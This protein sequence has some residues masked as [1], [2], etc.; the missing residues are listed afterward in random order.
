MRGGVATRALFA[1]AALVV[2]PAAPAGA[3][4]LP[5]GRPVAPAG[6][7]TALQAFPTGVAAAPDGKTVLAIGGPVIQGGAPAGPSGGVGLMVVDA[8]TG[9]VRQTLN[10]DDAF[11]GVVY[12]PSGTHAYVAGG[13]GATIHTFS[14]ASDG[15]LSQGSDLSAT[16]F[17]SGLAISKDGRT[18]WAAE[19]TANAVEQMDLT[20]RADR[21]RI[22]VPSP[23][24]LALSA[25]GKTLYASD[26]RG[27]CLSA[28][29]L[30]TNRTRCIH[31]GAHPTGVATSK[32][33]ILAA[34]SNDATLA[35]A[36]PGKTSA[37]LMSLA[38]VGRRSD[39][40]NDVVLA[41]D[42]QTAYVSLGADDAVAV[43]KRTRTTSTTAGRPGTRGRA[44]S[45]RSPRHERSH[46]HLRRAAARNCRQAPR[47]RP[48][49]KPTWKL[50][51]LI[52]TG[53][54][55]TALAL[56]PNGRTLH[57]ISARGLGHSAAATQPYSEPDPA[58]T[59]PDGAYGTVGTLETIALPD[60]RGLARDTAVVRAYLQRRT[61]SGD[62]GNPIV[63]GRAGPIKHVIYITRENKT[64]DA[65]LG[66]LHPGP[67]TSLA[68]FG[69]PITPNL[70]ALERTFV[71]AQSFYYQGF[72]STVGHM[73]EDA[74]AVSDLY[75]HTQAA[76]TGAHTSHVS[77]S[78]SDPENYP[79]TG[80]LAEQVWHA[81]MTV[82]TYNEETVQQAHLLPDA[83]QAPTS[84]FPNYNLHISDTSREAGWETEFN[85]F[86]S[87]HCT[88][89]VAATYGTA[90]SLPDFEYVYFGEDHTTIVDEPGYPTIQAQVADNDYATGKLIDAV[91][92]SPD[93]S[94][95]LVIVLDDDPQGTGDHVSEYRGFVAVASPWVKRGL[96][97]TT[98]YDLTSA[99]AAID[100]IL[101][102]PPLTDYA[103]TTRPLD[104]FFTS[105]P[106]ARPFNVDGSGVAANPFVALPGARPAAD[107]RH[108]IYSFTKPDATDPRITGAATWRQV[109]GSAP[110]RVSVP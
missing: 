91:S 68:V 30:K 57:V 2:F 15:T 10:V 72:A 37:K 64:Y 12:D 96:I 89:A 28:I 18:L 11:Q 53:W 93:W 29:T 76:G 8:A 97:T 84:V 108:G 106:D 13:A 39:A 36:T 22:T 83:L 46:G 94:S 109:K 44:S 25:D 73:W 103:A 27:S 85:Q 51:G 21:T 3:A 77:D 4:S 26:W 43:L 23:D 102:L 110:P 45:C 82:R 34:D 40:P 69:Q 52:P 9:Q 1:T 86:E 80:T 59:V 90:C 74:G 20:G 105:T 19:P 5:T 101:G 7:V 107:P 49:P 98:R 75:E 60:D 41:G 65:D 17:V 35:L 104:E 87:H 55:P 67:G 95:T 16:D 54:Y 33:T 63:A 100:R 32:G 6:R 79:A 31:V 56:S 50:A 78:W 38:L 24:R 92:H 42:G 88:G 58:A 70:H 66:D 48:R 61:V 62:A 99:V 71:E 14:V 47:P 81:G